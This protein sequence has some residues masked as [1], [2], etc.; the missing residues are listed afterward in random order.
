[1]IIGK[2]SRVWQLWMD[3]QQAVN[4]ADFIYIF[5]IYQQHLDNVST[6]AHIICNQPIHN[7]ADREQQTKIVDCIP[8]TAPEAPA[9]PRASWPTVAGKSTP[10]CKVR[11]MGSG[12]LKMDVWIVVRRQWQQWK[13]VLHPSSS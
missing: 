13:G 7:K 6:M 9:V 10:T 1:M 8:V 3:Y 4:K 11:E 5:T 2:Y 12:N